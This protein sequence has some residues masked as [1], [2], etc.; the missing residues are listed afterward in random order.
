MARWILES[1]LAPPAPPT[2]WL[3]R[4]LDAAEAPATALVAGPG[5]GKTLALLGALVDAREAGTPTVWYTLDADDSDPAGV[6]AHLA[7]GVAAHIPQFGEAVRALAAGDAPDPRRLWQGFFDSLASFN[8]P[9]FLLVF[10]DFQH[11]QVRQ[12]AL[13]AA[14]VAHSAKLPPGTRLLIAT[15]ERLPVVR[16]ARLRTLDAQALRFTPEEEHAFLAARAPAGLVPPAWQERARGLDGWPL[17]L[18]LATAAAGPTGPAP[19]ADRLAEYVSQELV[20]AQP[21]ALQAFM[22]EAAMLHEVTPEACREVFGRADAQA[23]LA[24]LEAHHLIQRTADGASYRFPPYLREFLRAEVE[25]AIAL[26]RRAAW[27]ERAAAYHRRQD[28]PE[29]AM[30]HHLAHADWEGAKDVARALFPTMRFDGRQLQARRWLEAFPASVAAHDPWLQIWRGHAL[31]RDGASQDALGAYERAR[32]LY[33]DGQDQAG[34][35]KAL[36]GMLNTRLTLMDTTAVPRLLADAKGHAGARADEDEVDLWLIRAADGERTGDMA[37]MRAC[38]EAAL[39]VPIGGNIEIAAS[40]C[41]AHMNLFTFALHRGEL[42]RAE[43]HVA[44]AVALASAWPFYPYRLSASILEAHLRLT[45]GDVEAAGAILAGL[46]PYW[47]EVLDWHDG[48]IAHTVLGHHHQLRGDW[49]EA[50]EALNQALVSF[51]RAGYKEG[52]KVPLERLMWVALHRRQY[53]RVEGL[54]REAGAGDS[55]HD[56]A[57]AIPG[58]RALH[59]GGKPA[60]ALA[61][62]APARKALEALGANLSLARALLY[63]AATLGALG[64]QAEGAQRLAQG[65]AAAERHGY[66]FLL[67]QDQLLWEEL[68][69]LPRGGDGVP[70]AVLAP[71]PDGL[72]TLGLRC[73]GSFEVRLGGVLL[74]Q[75]PR[76]K[77]KLLL[78]ALALHPGGLPQ[79]E[80]AELI[81]GDEANPANVLRVNTWALRRALEPGLEK[82]EESHFIVRDGDVLRLAWD[83]V[84]GLDL[85]DHEAAMVE[86]DALRT[87]DPRAAT[88]AYD[89][90][91][92]LVR[93]NLLDDGALYAPLAARRD[94]VNRRAVEALGWLCAHHRKLGDYRRAEAALA[95]AAELAPW[96]E[97]VYLASMRLYRALGQTDKL[98][99][100]YWDC[101][102]ALKAHLDRVPSEAFEAAYRGLL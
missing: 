17:G 83:R 33:V 90:G 70:S 82:G 101:R 2:G 62:I 25:R 16:G 35:F 27:H 72:D 5:Y 92:A 18:D 9:G 4:R 51:T 50:E 53:A 98:R 42:A 89:R 21:A 86:G 100:A 61:A 39:G 37:A 87:S 67:E 93:G 74:D 71:A 69:A 78:A 57:L 79:A 32:T 91:L 77:A 102:R 10:D 49:R 14:L 11:L 6:F 96:D 34:A 30:P 38:N 24:R 66:G 19:A 84:A 28:R 76:R 54:W 75:W 36:V 31:A 8:L 55:P 7:A 81:G 60:E 88:A 40:H 97:E 56:L 58:A 94:A 48:A 47:R 15:R 99:R 63:E 44:E 64:R 85:A 65:L 68:R 29:L 20:L 26:D 52:R 1:K 22:L 13:A 95:R 41:I 59:L 80:L 23:L 46:P 45:Q 12:P 73:L 43:A 3:R